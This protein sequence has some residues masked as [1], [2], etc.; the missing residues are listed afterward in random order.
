MKSERNLLRAGLLT[1]AT[2]AAMCAQ[3]TPGLTTIYT[4]TGGN[5]GMNPYTALTVGKGGVLYGTTTN[6]GKDSDGLVFSLKPPA[7]PGGL[8]TKQTILQ[9][10]GTDG[11]F[12]YGPLVIGANGVLY[13]TTVGRIP[14][15]AKEF[16]AVAFSLTPPSPSNKAWT[17]AV[18]FN[19]EV[20]GPEGAVFGPGGAA[21]RHA[22]V[23][24]FQRGWRGVL[25]DAG[26]AR[27]S[28]DGDGSAPVPERERRRPQA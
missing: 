13:G 21:L 11:A 23:G 14:H 26:I 4:F 1:V 20:S 3:A 5:D 25:V 22:G 24:A 28:L 19:F 8:W 16:A 18:L 15:G 2:A 6:G 17:E 12:P 7:S 10:D 9:F 27:Q